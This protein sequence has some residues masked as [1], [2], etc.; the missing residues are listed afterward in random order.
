M[1]RS[2]C[3]WIERE[4]LRKTLDCRGRLEPEARR[5]LTQ[6]DALKTR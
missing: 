4:E 6:L 3:A 2:V 1:S 5:M